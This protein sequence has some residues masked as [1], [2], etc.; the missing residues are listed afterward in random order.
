EEVSLTSLSPKGRGEEDGSRRR[1]QNPADRRGD[2]RQGVHQPAGVLADVPGVVLPTE[3]P[4][5]ARAVPPQP[6]RRRPP[7]PDLVRPARA[8]SSAIWYGSRPPATSQVITQPGSSGVG[9]R[10]VTRYRYR[11][12]D[13]LRSGPGRAIIITP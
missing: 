9:L 4:V 1:G 7:P 12:S 13:R 5:G 6:A 10:Y 8:R 11:A 3:H 2:R